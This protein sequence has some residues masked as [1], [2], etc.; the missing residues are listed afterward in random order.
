MR[1]TGTGYGATCN[2]CG[3]QLYSLPT[4][5]EAKKQEFFWQVKEPP[6]KQHAEERRER[7]ALLKPLLE[8]HA[9]RDQV[10]KSLGLEFLDYSADSTNRS[11][12]RKWLFLDE[13]DAAVARYP[14]ILFH[15]NTITMTWL[16]FDSER[17]LQGYY[18][19]SA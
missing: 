9:E 10:T 16:F 3:V 7:E 2:K 1:V 19:R 5:E 17:R 11:E 13:V 18:I 14:G 6:T 12:L 15:M 4:E 8:S